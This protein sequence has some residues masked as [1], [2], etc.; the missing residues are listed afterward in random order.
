MAKELYLYSGIYDFT[1][2]AIISQI[3]DHMG[4][5][6]D[7][8]TNS[9]GGEVKAGWGIAAKISEHGNVNMKVDGSADSMTAN[10]L[11]YAKS[12]ECLDVTTFTLHRAAY[13]SWYTPTEE[14]QAYLL[15]M[16]KDLKAK[17]LLK[18]DSEVFKKVT[19]F[20]IDE[21]FDPEQ[22]I[23]ITI[24]ASDAKKI[25]LV[26][27][28]NKLTPSEA[29]AFN[30]RMA[31]AYNEQNPNLPIK[32]TVDEIKLKH[33]E[34]YN[35]IVKAGIEQEKDRVGSFLAFI[36][37]D[38]EGVKKG[39][40]AGTNL[41]AT[42]MAEFSRKAFSA[43]EIKKIEADNA[44]PLQTGEAPATAETEK[45]QALAVFEKNVSAQLGLKTV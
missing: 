33:P 19:G 23:N 45:E 3:N 25:G 21:M 37:V 18:L 30:K 24:N 12:A 20:T 42:A 4:D 39:I 26:Q 1:A 29:E 44:K 43:T 5:K 8:R 35:Q 13:S 10:L 2:E 22:R 9:G 27:K 41:S 31:F 28:V 38:P 17:M 11:M 14:D 6:I 15:N 7:L 36:D 40:E 32:M 16:N 34:A